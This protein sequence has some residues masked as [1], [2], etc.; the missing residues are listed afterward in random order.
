MLMLPNDVDLIIFKYIHRYKLNIVHR[1][2]FEIFDWDYLYNRGI[3]ID[4][5]ASY[6]YRFMETGVD[7]D[8][9]IYTLTASPLGEQCLAL[10]R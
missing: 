7:M 6:N 1:Q 4:G 10:A 2:Y 8:M 9:G 5:R 3:M